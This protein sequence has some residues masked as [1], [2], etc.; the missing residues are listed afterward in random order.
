MTS[1]QIEAIKAES[2]HVGGAIFSLRTGN[3]AQISLQ[4]ALY[5][6]RTKRAHQRT[7]DNQTFEQYLKQK[8]H[9][10]AKALYQERSKEAYLQARTRDMNQIKWALRSGSTKCL[11]NA[12]IHPIGL[13]IMVSDPDN[14][15]Q[16]ISAPQEVMHASAR[17]FSKLYHR[18]P[19]PSTLKPW[20]TTPSIKAVKQWVA[21][22]PFKW[23]QL[24]NI[25]SFRAMLHKGNPRP[26]SGPDGWEKWCVKTLTDRTLSL[27]VNSIFPGNIKEVISVPLYN[28]GLR[29][30]L[31][32]YAFQFPCQFSYDLA[33]LLPH[34]L[35]GKS[36][37]HKLR[38]RWVYNAET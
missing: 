31:T 19:P 1:P 5:L 30:N 6:E 11:V 35:R 27:V 20:L 10:L 36:Q 4:T 15:D 28:K 29:T 3:T 12:G 32:N 14:L 21:N 34:T 22:E 33:E 16:I 23:P 2:R 17:Y 9:T 8:R 37:R 26:S 38:H 13:P 25:Q 24:A 18:E 7:P